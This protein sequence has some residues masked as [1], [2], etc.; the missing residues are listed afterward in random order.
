MIVNYLI[1]DGHSTSISVEP[2]NKYLTHLAFLDE[3]ATN[4]TVKPGVTSSTSLS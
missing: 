1:A 2:E 3:I 4:P